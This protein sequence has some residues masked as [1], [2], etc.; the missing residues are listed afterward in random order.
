[1]SLGAEIAAALPEMRLQAESMMQ[2]SCTIT[3]PAAGVWDE[4]SGTYSTS[5]TLLYTGPCRVRRPNASD[6]Q[7]TAGE[8]GYVMGDV[9]VSVPVSAPVVPAGATITITAS[10]HDPQMVGSAFTVLGP[11]GQTHSTARRYRCAEVVR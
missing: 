6:R 5:L 1:M 2:V 3:I 11:H 9:I 4:T 8:A 10:V 7:A